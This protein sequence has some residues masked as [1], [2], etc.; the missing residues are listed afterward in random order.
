MNTISATLLQYSTVLHQET[1]KGERTKKSKKK[2]K[3]DAQCTKVYDLFQTMVPFV[4]FRVTYCIFVNKGNMMCLSI[5]I[6]AWGITHWHWFAYTWRTSW[7]IIH[8]S[9]ILTN[10][11]KKL[12]KRSTIFIISFPYPKKIMPP[13]VAQSNICYSKMFD[14]TKIM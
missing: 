8:T 4:Q 10:Y 14:I 9:L 11:S 12:T 13:T 6:V 1:L 7:T 5:F 2:R 3:G